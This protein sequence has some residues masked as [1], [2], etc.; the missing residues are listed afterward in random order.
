MKWVKKKFERSVSNINCLEKDKSA[1]IDVKD[2]AK[3]FKAR[4]QTFQSLK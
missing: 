3:D 2:I 1:K 4:N